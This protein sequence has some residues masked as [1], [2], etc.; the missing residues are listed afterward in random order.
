MTNLSLLV[1]I[2]SESRA[3]NVNNF[4]VA[5]SF[6]VDEDQYE[7]E[8]K[9]TLEMGLPKEEKALKINGRYVEG[10]KIQSIV[11]E[12]IPYQISQFFLFDGEL[13]KSLKPL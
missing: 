5:L 10:G 8:R 7:L 3:N 12:L 4:Q 13:L 11:E 2:N 9:I 6:L 1:L